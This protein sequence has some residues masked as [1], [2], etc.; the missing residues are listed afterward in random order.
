MSHDCGAE[1]AP[2]DHSSAGQ[3]LSWL[4]SYSFSAFGGD[5]TAAFTLTS[6]L[7]PQAM[8]YSTNLA[9]LPP[10]TGLFGAAIPPMICKSPAVP[11]SLSLPPSPSALSSIREKPT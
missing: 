5:I 1:G 6:M 4:P 7:V 10:I 8:S 11:S 2:A 9:N 3:V